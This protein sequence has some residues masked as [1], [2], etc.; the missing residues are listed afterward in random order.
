MS[1]VNSVTIS[2][3]LTRD[4]ETRWTADDGASSI[5]S[6]GI[7]V[8]R[9]RFNKETEEY[10]D[11]VSFFDVDVFG[12]FANLV[13]KKLRKADAATIQGRLEQQS[14]E[15]DGQ[16]R[17]SVKV[18]A[19]AIDSQGFFRPKDED[20]IPSSGDSGGGDEGGSQ[21]VASP[22]SDDIPF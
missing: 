3:N 4:P 2:G 6:L 14:Y 21:V 10:E 1:N 18:I 8:N 20:A 7:A 12:G 22:A 16:K 5:V 17:S 15:K 9:S 13:G 11:E 19:T